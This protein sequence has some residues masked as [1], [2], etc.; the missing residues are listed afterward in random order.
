MKIHFKRLNQAVHFQAF[1]EDGQSV[2]IDGSPAVGGEN[3]G[4]RPMQLV[5]TGLGACSGIDVVDI[6][7]KQRQPLKDMEIVIDGERE[8]K[9]AP[10]VFTNIIIHYTLIGDLD[11]DKVRKAIELSVDKYCSVARMLE[12]TAKIEYTY[13]ILPE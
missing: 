3:A 6:L 4:M 13:E 11:A 10:S 9:P 8:N 2:H 7:K 5:L 1:N 12:K